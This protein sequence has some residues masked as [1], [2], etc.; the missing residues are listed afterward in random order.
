MLSSI[1][2]RPRTL[3][4][5]SLATSRTTSNIRGKAISEHSLRSSLCQTRAFVYIRNGVQQPSNPIDDKNHRNEDISPHAQEWVVALKPGLTE[6]EY[7]TL[8]TSFE[9]EFGRALKIACVSFLLS[10][11]RHDP[12]YT[13]PQPFE[14]DLSWSA[15]ATTPEIGVVLPEDVEADGMLEHMEK[16]GENVLG[17]RHRYPM[18]DNQAAS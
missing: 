18:T 7:L 6:P 9:Q 15:N 3:R 17:Y 13:P 16:W 5:S 10:Q 2:R 4:L 11:A 1:L 12:A 14:I 8:A